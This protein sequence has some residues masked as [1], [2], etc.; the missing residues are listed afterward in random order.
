MGDEE[1]A[2]YM[3]ASPERRALDELALHLTDLEAWLGPAAWAEPVA[4]PYVGS[5][6]LFW[7]T[8]AGDTPPPEV[9]APSVTGAAWPFDGPIDQFGDP[10][11]EER[12]GHLDLGQAFE[13]LRLMREHGG[14]DESF[15]IMPRSGARWVR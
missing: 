5:S 8:P 2:L 1:E 4:K 12:C 3:V 14:P 6:Y 9:D 10:V 15:G 11:G 7:L 13:T